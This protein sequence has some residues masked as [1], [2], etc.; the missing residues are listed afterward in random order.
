LYLSVGGLA[1]AV[2]LA[3]LLAARPAFTIYY[4]EAASSLLHDGSLSIG[5]AKTAALEPL[6]PI[7]LAAVR[8]AVGDRPL[9]VQSAQALIAASGALFL[10]RLAFE[11]TAKHQTAMIAAS[12]FAVYPLLVRH[13]VDGTESALVTALLIAFACRFV[14]MRTTV[15]AVVVGVLL[16]GAIL[17]RIVA[18]PL[19]A[20][21]PSIAARKSGRSA[22]AMAGAALIVLAPYAVRNYRLSGVL[23]PAR[24]GINLFISNSEYSA[25]VVAEYGP[26]IL[27]PFAQSRLASEGLAD[28]PMTP[29]AEQQSD[30]AFR[31]LA[32]AEVRRH[33]SDT[34]RLKLANLITFFSPM[35]VPHFVMSGSTS[36][37][38]GPDGQSVVTGAVTRPL[39]DRMLYTVSYSVVAGLALIGVYRRRRYLAGDDAILWAVL[40]TFAAVHAVYFPSTRYRAP[41]EFVLLLYAAVGADVHTRGIL[42]KLKLR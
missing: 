36:I 42:R 1:A 26:D 21:A 39:R 23:L 17:T 32:L 18:L 5:G 9:L 19:L 10:Y 2:R 14:G 27:M 6:Y 34:V 8:L 20:M 24:D 38:L 30:A 11:I 31:A 22:V 40:L 12:L 3:Y 25:G 28:L 4:W 41:V 29:Q 16:G 13:S 7:F 35:L 33:P 15:D 37:Q